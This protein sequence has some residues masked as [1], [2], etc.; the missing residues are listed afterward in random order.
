[1]VVGLLT[2]FV[3]LLYA[4]A[5]ELG[6]KGVFFALAFVAGGLGV[7]MAIDNPAPFTI[8]MALTDIVLVLMLFGGDVRIR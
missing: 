3:V 6:L 1:M 5:E 7:A 2:V 4:N 8:A